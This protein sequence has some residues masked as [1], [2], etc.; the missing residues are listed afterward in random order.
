MTDSAIVIAL[1]GNHLLR[2]L[3]MFQLTICNHQ[4]R[5]DLYMS[6]NPPILCREC[7]LLGHSGS[8]CNA[9]PTCG[10]C[11]A[12]YLTG[13]HRC[14]ADKTASS[15]R[16]AHLLF[17]CLNCHNNLYVSTDQV[18]PARVTA[19]ECTRHL[20]TSAEEEEAL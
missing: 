20:N 12:N 11:G 1:T 6:Y 4:C 5:L 2:S 8:K 14:A 9:T 17:R 13:H 15:S 19:R 16:L 3:G 7:S 18:C 10:Y